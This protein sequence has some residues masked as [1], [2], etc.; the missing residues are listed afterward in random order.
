[1]KNVFDHTITALQTSS[2]CLY[3]LMWLCSKQIVLPTTHINIYNMY[4]K[5]CMHPFVNC[6]YC[7]F[8]RINYSRNSM[9][10]WWRRQMETFFALL[11]LCGGNPP[12]IGE[13]LSQRPVTPSFDV[14]FYL[15]LNKRLCKQSRR[16]W[17]DTPLRPLWRH[18]KARKKHTKDLSW[19]RQLQSHEYVWIRHI[20]IE[21]GFCGETLWIN[22]H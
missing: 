18:G 8:P 11:V 14:F 1:M 20:C 7:N 6:M 2:L 17:F 19:R 10:P 4:D 9:F 3:Q 21:Y 5:N 22:Q 16:R 13:F 15:R 12:V